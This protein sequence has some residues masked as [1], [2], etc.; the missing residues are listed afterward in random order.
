MS[1]ELA[2]GRQGHKLAPRNERAALATLED[3]VGGRDK[4]IEH[5]NHSALTKEQEYFI[6]QLADPRNSKQS[7][8]QIAKTAKISFG[9]LIKFFQDAGFV[10]A[11]L[12]ANQKIWEKL[13]EVAGDVMEKAVTRVVDCQTCLGTGELV[14]DLAKPA[15][16]KEGDPLPQ[17][18]KPCFI[19]FG[20]KQITIEPAHEVQKTAL[21][22]GG[23][24]KRGVNVG[25][26]V[27][28]QQNN[29]FA[30]LGNDH[31][32]DLRAATDKILFPS[33]RGER[34]AQDGDVVEGEVV[35]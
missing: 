16:W 24:L 1:I 26:N 30:M 12:A 19:C 23:L 27:G 9:N 14:Y 8:A 11:Q 22:I 25:V 6:G 34:E 5:L 7:L 17:E 33:R 28:V 29:N 15:S 31:M 2:D 21:E 18:T 13:P 4:L 35:K 20:R 32:R 10:K 3:E